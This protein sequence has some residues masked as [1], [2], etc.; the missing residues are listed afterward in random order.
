MR[1]E[2]V[3][4][5]RKAVWWSKV[6]SSRPGNTRIVAIVSRLAVNDRN[7]LFN[8]LLLLLRRRR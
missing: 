5:S 4:G 3:E 6:L 8:D 7:D 2:E 1:R